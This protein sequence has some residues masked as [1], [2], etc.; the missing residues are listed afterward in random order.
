MKT[1]LVISGG[2]AKGAFA[3][4]IVK[5]LYSA[6]GRDGWFDIIG[7]TSTG[8]LI[9]PLAALLKE[10]SLAAAAME[11]LER[12]Y[13]TVTTRDILDK[14]SIFTLLFKPDALNG[15]APLASIIETHLTPQ[16]F[17]YLRSLEAPE[18][19]VVYTNFR[20]G[21]SEHISPR[22]VGM[23]LA[24]FRQ[25]V[26]AS[27]S[28]PVYM[29]AAR[30]NNDACYD[31]GVRELLPLAHAI[32]LGAERLL[33]ISLDPPGL[34]ED[35]SPFTRLDQVLLRSLGIMLDEALNDDTGRA[36]LINDAVHAKNELRAQFAGQPEALAKIEAIFASH[37]ALFDESRRILD[38]Q[39]GLRPD[40]PLI[41][42]S[43]EFD[44]VKMKQWFEAGYE[45]ARRV[46]TSSPF[47][48]RSN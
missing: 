29:E 19:Y 21:Q 22:T 36:G 4:G 31:G 13:T 41:D 47:T 6:Y 24:S 44:P 42:D 43:L 30:I 8:A 48:A 14:R 15:T 38:I 40:Q 17:Q 39:P 34:G 46:V 25:A 7:G 27:S 3:A 35:K 28:I 9:T 18:T 10:P 5:Y 12:L 26:L 2:G 33:P 37:P 16:R 45:Q 23:D 1:A 20:T 11:T 32:D